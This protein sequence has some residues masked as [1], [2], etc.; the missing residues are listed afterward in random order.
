MDYC[1]GCGEGYVGCAVD[2]WADDCVAVGARVDWG[3][4]V[5]GYGKSIG[6]TIQPVD[7]LLN[8]RPLDAHSKT[9]NPLDQDQNLPRP[10][11]PPPP[12]PLKDPRLEPHRLITRLQRIRPWQSINQVK[13]PFHPTPI[14]LSR[15]VTTPQTRRW[16][17]RR[18]HQR[19]RRS[20]NHLD[21]WVRFGI[22]LK[23]SI[24][25][26]SMGTVTCTWAVVKG[27][28]WEDDWWWYWGGECDCYCYWHVP[29]V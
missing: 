1:V 13:I 11:A 5:V 18:G 17:S 23:H 21:H 19:N 29:V 15:K 24:L 4:A 3:E 26:T 12:P 2:Y 25:F 22:N 20:S 9:L 16:P 7:D 27:V 6:S 8:L 28:L 10:Q 14:L